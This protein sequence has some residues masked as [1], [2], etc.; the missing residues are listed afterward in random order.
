MDIQ[1]Y[2]R[3]LGEWA[4]EAARLARIA[5]EEGD[6]RECSLKLMC[7]S[8]YSQMLISLGSVEISGR[9]KGVIHAVRL[10]AEAAEQKLRALNDYDAAD[11]ERVKRDAIL[12]VE[13]LLYGEAG[14]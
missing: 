9:R 7:A 6:E 4:D 3:T 13:K 11:R 10:N 1:T 8:M 2:T 5:R 14:V 12:R